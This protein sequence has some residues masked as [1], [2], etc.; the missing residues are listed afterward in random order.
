MKWLPDVAPIYSHCLGN[1]GTGIGFFFFF[2]GVQGFWL[3]HG[4]GGLKSFYGLERHKVPQLP[5]T[6]TVPLNPLPLAQTLTFLTKVHIVP[7]GCCFVLEF[8]FHMFVYWLDIEVETMSTDSLQREYFKKPLI[9]PSP[10]SSHS[11][12]GNAPPG[13]RTTVSPVYLE[14]QWMRGV[15]A[16][17]SSARESRLT[18]QQWFWL[19]SFPSCPE[20]GSECDSFGHG[21]WWAISLHPWQ[22]QSAPTLFLSFLPACGL[23]ISIFK[24]LLSFLRATTQKILKGP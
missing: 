8:M 9:R 4:V 23:I 14:S 10:Q 20:S 2:S 19:H 12:H 6:A 13:A 24:W 17:A 22:Q 7:G 15:G 21:V 1:T 11:S 16:R 3:T 5:V 18:A